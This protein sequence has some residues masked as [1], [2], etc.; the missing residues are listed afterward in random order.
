MSGRILV[1]DD[2][3][4]SR[5]LLKARLAAAFYTVILAESGAEA[6]RLAEENEPDIVLLDVKMPDIDGFEVCR[7]LK[8]NPHLAHIPV[9]M[10]TASASEAEKL[11]GLR[12]GADDF[13]TKPFSELS[14]LARIRNLLRMKLMFDELRL[15]GETI[16]ALGLPDI[17]ELPA[18]GAKRVTRILTVAA[19]P[20]VADTWAQALARQLSARTATAQGVADALAAVTSSLPDAVVVDQEIGAETDGRR[21]V[22]IL[23]ARPETRRSVILFVAGEGRQD[24]AAQALDLGASDTLIRPFEMAELVTRTST[25]LARKHLSDRLRESIREGLMMAAID[26]LTG[27]FNR[28]YALRHLR[29]MLAR[30]G[31]SGR[32]V[33]ALMLDL[34]GFKAINDTHGHLAGDAVLREFARR[35]QENVRGVD[36]VARL[37]GEEFLVV[38]PDVDASVALSVAERIRKAVERPEFRLGEGEGSVRVTVSIGVGLSEPGETDSEALI[39]RADAALYASK[40]AGRNRVTVEKAA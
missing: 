38:M 13:L 1:V 9:I 32:P 21:L 10:V 37:G 8:A 33:A 25:Q 23:R 36:L 28:H 17:A 26:S 35:L 29:A 6:L 39:R 14:L 7:R 2:T 40:N 31:E 19:D 5:V 4:S 16:R 27:L 20:L 22:S 24:L 34:D 3:A 30:A 18:K 11:R 15:R 12:A